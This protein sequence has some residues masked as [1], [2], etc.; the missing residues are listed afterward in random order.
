ML[1]LPLADL[2]GVNLVFP[3]RLGQLLPGLYFAQDLNFELT[4]KSSSYTSH[5][6]YSFSWK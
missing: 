3:A 5:F 6:G 4:A 1:V 2:V